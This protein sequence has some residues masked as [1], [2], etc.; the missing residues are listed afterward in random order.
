M[1]V[2][3]MFRGGKINFKLGLSLRFLEHIIFYKVLPYF[4]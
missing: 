4:Y 1:I 3:K 2:L